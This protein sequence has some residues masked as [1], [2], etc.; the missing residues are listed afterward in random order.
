M[1]ARIYD[2]VIPTELNESELAGYLADIFHENASKK[3]PSVVRLG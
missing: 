3:H 1:R 2:A